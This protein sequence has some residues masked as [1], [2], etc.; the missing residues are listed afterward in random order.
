MGQEQALPGT[1]MWSFK[2]K[3]NIE[4][5][6]RKYSACPAEVE[7]GRKRG[8]IFGLLL[9]KENIMTWSICLMG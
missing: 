2:E 8:E 1:I 3:E 9:E 7:Q 4:G 5:K 6:G